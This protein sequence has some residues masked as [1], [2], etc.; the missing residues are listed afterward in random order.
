MY[1]KQSAGKRVRR[2]HWFTFLIL[3]GLKMTRSL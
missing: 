2:S 3:I 1:L